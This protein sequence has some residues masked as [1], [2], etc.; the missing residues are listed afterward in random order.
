M[1]FI[2]GI[3]NNGM[4]PFKARADKY[5]EKYLRGWDELRER[6]YER[7]KHIG[8]IDGDRWSLT[9]R[10]LVPVDGANNARQRG[11]EGMSHTSL[12]RL[13]LETASGCCVEATA[14]W[15]DNPD[16]APDAYPARACRDRAMPG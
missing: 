10:S 13:L 2:S 12:T 5:Y 1:G 14:R 3:K 8:L 16:L 15:A 4:T 11:P 6:R 7:M 9:E